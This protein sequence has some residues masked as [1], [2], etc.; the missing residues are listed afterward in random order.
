MNEGHAPGHSLISLGLLTT[1]RQTA[2]LHLLLPQAPLQ[3]QKAGRNP[4]P[5]SQINLSF[6][7]GFLSGECHKDPQVSGT[8]WKP[9]VIKSRLIKVCERPSASS[10]PHLLRTRESTST[11]PLL[12]SISFR[13]NEI[14]KPES[15]R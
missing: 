5:A 9:S 3:Q 11:L 7:K 15:H 4:D 13:V 1:M 2:S 14:V 12:A 6:F 10:S 8:H